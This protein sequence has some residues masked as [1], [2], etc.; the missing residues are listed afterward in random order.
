MFAMTQY[1]QSANKRVT[2][3]SVRMLN[4][5]KQ[6]AYVYKFIVKNDDY[7]EA[8]EF[9][10]QVAYLLL[11]FVIMHSIVKGLVR[12]CLDPFNL[13]LNAKILELETEV[14]NSE[15]LYAN[16]Y[17]EKSNADEKIAEL[18]EKLKVAE[19]ALADVKANYL[20][21]RNAAQTFLDSTSEFD[22]NG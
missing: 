12:I 5:C 17:E 20:C 21:C 19:K 14:A 1:A 13:R 18:T 22:T 6:Y 4:A 2:F 16:L 11:V 3:P 8:A 9:F 7:N 15:E 10:L